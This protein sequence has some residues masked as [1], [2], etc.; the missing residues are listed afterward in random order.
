MQFPVKKIAV[1]KGA[2]IGDPNLAYPSS[3]PCPGYLYKGHIYLGKNFLWCFASLAHYE[4][5]YYTTWVTLLY[6][7]VI[8]IGEGKFSSWMVKALLFE[9]ESEQ[10]PKDP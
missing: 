5:L 7:I 2:Q 8:I 10:N 1:S 9:R 3:N 4:A 6:H